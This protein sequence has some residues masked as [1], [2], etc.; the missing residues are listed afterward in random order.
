MAHCSKLLSQWLAQC[1]VAPHESAAA[2]KEMLY[3][4]TR[5][6]QRVFL[7]VTSSEAGVYGSSSAQSSLSEA[8]GIV[9]PRKSS[10]SKVEGMEWGMSTDL[11]RLGRARTAAAARRGESSADENG[12]AID[13]T[14]APKKVNI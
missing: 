7:Q 6:S 12:N 1:C 4:T 5:V 3:P 2:I 14:D 13:A 8:A 11:R 10:Q 9:A